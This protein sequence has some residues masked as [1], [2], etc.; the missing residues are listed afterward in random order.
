MRDPTVRTHRM[1]GCGLALFAAVGCS[2]GS[3]TPTPTS[4][5][6]VAIQTPLLRHAWDAF[7][8]GTA[9]PGAPDP[10]NASF[11]ADQD[12]LFNASQFPVTA[13]YPPNYHWK[14]DPNLD[15]RNI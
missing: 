9:V 7:R 14:V 5:A 15:A 11:V 8:V 12:G 1:F 10:T 6:T 2:S 4:S 3:P 13:F